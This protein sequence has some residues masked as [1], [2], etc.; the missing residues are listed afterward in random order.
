MK[1]EELLREKL[2]DISNVKFAYLF[3][4][5]ADGSF[6]DRSDVDVAVYLDDDSFDEQLRV[7]YELSKVVE[8][9]VD[10]VLLNSV[11]NLYLC[12]DIITKGILLKDAEKRIDFELRKHHQYLDY[13]E[14]KKRIDAA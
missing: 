13:I 6:H 7:S 2:R 8:K 4:S 11:K 10:L 3:G 1:I 5:Y 14:F 9:E 12:E